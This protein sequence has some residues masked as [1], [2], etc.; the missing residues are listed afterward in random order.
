MRMF[1]KLR[2]G[3]TLTTLSVLMIAAGT[4][5]VAVAANALDSSPADPP[6]QVAGTISLASL[7]VGDEADISLPGIG[8][9]TVARTVTGLSLVSA[10]A[11]PGWQ[12][13]VHLAEGPEVEVRYWADDVHHGLNIELEDGLIRVRSSTMTD[14]SG[15]EGTPVTSS[16]IST[17]S[18]LPSV[19]S[20]ATVQAVAVLDAGTVSYVV[21][22]LQLS[23][24]DVD[25]G[26]GWSSTIEVA[27]G[28]EVEVVFRKGGA[29]V[30]LDLELEDDQVR[31]RIRDRRSD[32]RTETR[33]PVDGSG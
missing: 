5:A 29:R 27:A 31:V 18:T 19:T 7:A 30:D 21:A 26:S 6:A 17:S 20:G 32:I 33:V 28:R 25:A 14:Q 11:D 23:I 15:D 4:A 2:D 8:T 13:M 22:G 16:T 24:V 1:R 10:T 9:A 3:V 12:V